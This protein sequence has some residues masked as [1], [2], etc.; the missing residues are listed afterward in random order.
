MN[1]ADR[2]ESWIE[3]LSNNLFDAGSSLDKTIEMMIAIGPAA[4]R[5]LTRYFAEGPANRFGW[6]P[7]NLKAAL[8]RLSQA[9]PDTFLASFPDVVADETGTLPAVLGRIDDP[10]VDDILNRVL[11][12]PDPDPDR[13]YTKIG[14]VRAL[15]ATP[16]P[17]VQRALIRALDHPSNSLTRAVAQTLGAIGDKT[18]VEPLERYQAAKANEPFKLAEEAE[19]AVLQIRTRLASGAPPAA[20]GNEVRE[21]SEVDRLIE[22]LGSDDQA[23]SESALRALEDLGEPARRRLFEATEFLVKIPWG[24]HPMDA[25]TRRSVALGR[26]GRIYPDVLLGLVRGKKYLRLD[27]IQGLGYTGDE[28][29][30]AIA[31]E[32]LKVCGDDR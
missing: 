28:R 9:D 12:N 5:R 20:Q 21:R 10:R 11:W 32:A 30:T 14:V 8:V 27:T 29:L 23:K 18:A 1:D 25:P 24:G 16:G 2:I 13:Q 26:L 22:R 31:R 19:R 7:E 4:V 17:R 6:Y 15:S 3:Q